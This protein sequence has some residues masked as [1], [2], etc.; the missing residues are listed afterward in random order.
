M[1]TEDENDET[2]FLSARQVAAYGQFDGPP[3]VEDLERFFF[4]DDADRWML[5]VR[6]GD[7]NRLGFALQLT[8]VRYLGTFLDDPLDVPTVVL[9][10]LAAQLKIADASC[11]KTY[12]ERANTKWEHRRQIAAEDGWREFAEVRNELCAWIDHRAWTTGAGPKAIFEGVLAWLRARRV[13]LPAVRE[14]ERLVATV[15]RQAH[16][17]LWTTLAQMVSAQQA[18]V[19]LDLVEVDEG[20]RVSKLE[21]LRQS[22]VDRTGKA[23]AG[24]LRRAFEVR[25]IGLG[26]TDVGAVP[27]RRVVDLARRGMSANA[28]DLRRTSPYDKRLATLLSTV[29]YLEAKAVDDALEL[30][31]LIMAN[32]LLARAERQS[33]AEKAKRYPRVARDAS[34]LAAVVAVL[35]ESDDWGADLSV[36]QLWDAIENVASRTELRAAVDRVHQ[37]APP[38]ADPDREWREALMGR[39]PLVRRFVCLLATTIEFG[40]TTDAAE[41]LYA[42]TALP[43]LLDASPTKRVPAG[44]LDARKISMEMITPGWRELV[45]RKD[46]PAETVD[47]VAYVFCV[48]D[49]FHQRL[50]RR[51]IFAAASSRWAD[52]RALLLSGETW[53]ERREQLLDSLQI[54]GEPGDLLAAYAAEL[55]GMWQYM[56]TRVEAGDV[57]VDGEGRV[58]AAAVQ[59]VARPDSLNELRDRCQDMMPEADIGDML[60]E[61]MGWLP[62][63]AAAYTHVSGGARLDE[64]MDLT[65]A[66]VLTSQALNVGWKPVITPGDPALNRSRISHVYQ[67]YVRAETHAAANGALIAGQ[68]GVPTAEIWGGGLVAAVDGTRFVV[69]VRSIYARPNPKYFGR[70]K[71]ATYL[72]MI[73]DQGVGIAG[74]VLSGTPK[75][76]LYAVDL[77]YRRDGGVRPEVFVSDTGSYSDMVFGML[78]LLGV[79]YRPEL[80]GLPDQKL[81]RIDPNADY[82]HLDAA[83]RGKIDLAKIKRHWDDICR[84]VA[85]VHCGA[86]SASDVMRMLQHGGQPTQLGDALAHFGRIFKTLHVLS[87]A[88]RES[89]R[90]DIKW[91]RN[92][93]EERHSLAKHV[94]HGRK[95]ELREAYH[96]GMED[97]LGALGLVVNAITLWNTV[98]LD[99]IL[100]RLRAEGYPVREADV[101]RLHPY[102]HRHI[103]VAGHYSF[104]P[105]ALGADG[106]RALRD[107]GTGDR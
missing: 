52:P 22:P 101:A 43:D 36:T 66:A 49:Q 80:A 42:L 69:P 11:V 58:H 55:D 107:P 38:D 95:G 84:I 68:A 81:W 31:D 88:D 46:R 59:A 23:L 4:L 87:Y 53:E 44:Y 93:Q 97:Q 104:T 35:L 20:Q 102:W 40:A 54:P 29:L 6:R 91:I 106:R 85:S 45:L 8:T 64:G 61:V 33:N 65:L 74:M 50:R 63:F 24:A 76:S 62:E 39:Y 103:N 37:A 86:I 15:V 7:A 57:T 32:E 73:N 83:A 77:M 19:L 79:D 75:D 105:P 5:E 3:P 70:K 48:L 82:G 13:L 60:L 9:D 34:K 16:G 18:A 51:D 47:K 26:A 21:K 10:E 67:N 12:V 30:F 94:F 17:R 98:Y 28:T 14:L 100:N 89:Y 71:G 78:K 1:S 72:N 92:L 96:A 27:Q 2:G 25:T 90:R 56:A 41:V 99:M